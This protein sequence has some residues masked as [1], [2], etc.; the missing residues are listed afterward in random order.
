[1]VRTIDNEPH[2]Y[3]L[4]VHVQSRFSG[5]DLEAPA[6]PEVCLAINRAYQQMIDVSLANIIAVLQLNRQR[7]VRQPVFIT[8]PVSIIIVLCPCP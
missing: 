8:L 2:D 7:Q 4:C 1:M 6:S 5:F 3:A